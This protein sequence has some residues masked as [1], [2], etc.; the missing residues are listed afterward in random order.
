MEMVSSTRFSEYVCEACVG[1]CETNE[2]G[3]RRSFCSR[4]CL[5]RLACS[6]VFRC[7]VPWFCFLVCYRC[8][9]C[10]LVSVPPRVVRIDRS[11][12]A[13]RPG[14]RQIPLAAGVPGD[15][16]PEAVGPQGG[17][18]FAAAD[19]SAGAPA[20]PG[21]TAGAKRIT[22]TDRAG[23]A[24]GRAVGV[25]AAG[26]V[27]EG[28]ALVLGSGGQEKGCC[29]CCC[30]C[31]CSCGRCRRSVDRANAPKGIGGGAREHHGCY[32]GTEGES[33][34]EKKHRRCRCRCRC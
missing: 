15:S 6:V 4:T 34:G 20:A 1:F 18:V 5:F 27:P 14:V 26:A 32:R 24:G 9:F 16:V 13:A 19:A 11:E 12:R 21:A 29:C 22:T 28:G 2:N 8:C 7:A 17:N 10:R 33:C 31:R 30:C 23:A 3:L 25:S